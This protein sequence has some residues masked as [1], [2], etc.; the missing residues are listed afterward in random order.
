MP[1]SFDFF[2][3]SLGLPKESREI[4]LRSPF[5][6]DKQAMVY[7]PTRF[8]SPFDSDFCARM[9]E[10]A[11]H[12]INKTKGRALFL[13]TSYKNM[14][15]IYKMFESGISFPL[16]MQG[17]KTKRALLQ[18][19][20]D[21]VDS[22]LLATSSFWQGID[23]PGESLSCVLIDKLPFEV[24]DDPITAARLD[25]LAGSGKNG[26]YEY[27]VPRAAIQLKQGVGRLI[28]SST[29]TGII[30]LFDSRLLTKSYGQVFLK[31]L[32]PCPVVHS[33]EAIDEFLNGVLRE[34]ATARS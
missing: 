31:S 14:H 34:D 1:D 16:L 24:P 19:F 23:I 27:Q 22:V 8:P 33:M 18:E 20:R 17:Q 13:F 9:A 15:E 5:A 28:R 29:D 10:Q 3:N 32:P 4:L 26:F 12:I 2:R 30:A 11:A 21:R 25:R 6:Y 7:I